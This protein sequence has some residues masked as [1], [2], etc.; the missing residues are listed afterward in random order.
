MKSY[1]NFQKILEIIGI[2]ILLAY[3]IFFFLTF[4]SLPDK[5]PA[6]FDFAGE[7]TR[8]GSKY[9]MVIM[10]VLGVI[11]YGGITILQKYPSAW[12]VPIKI[13]TENE[14]EAYSILRTVIIASKVEM[15]GIFALISYYSGQMKNIPT[16]MS[17]LFIAVPI[18]TIVIGL[19]KTFRIE[20]ESS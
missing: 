19:I 13:T 18:I 20:R 10:P 14:E 7:V 11:M 17:V 6:H 4:S 3:L 12:N 5:T 8:Y 2:I 9:E 1:T 16:Y 15:I